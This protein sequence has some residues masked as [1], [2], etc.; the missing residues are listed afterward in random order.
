MGKILISPLPIIGHIIPAM[1]VARRLAAAGHNIKFALP[2]QIASQVSQDF[3]CV[4]TTD[5]VFSHEPVTLRLS[6]T[7]A[8]RDIA[9]LKINIRFLFELWTESQLE[10]LRKIITKELPDLIISDTHHLAPIVVALE[11]QL[12]SAVLGVT[13]YRKIFKGSAPIGSGLAPSYKMPYAYIYDS[14]N[15]IIEWRS[16]NI[17]HTVTRRLT[18]LSPGLKSILQDA[19][20]SIFGI[21]QDLGT[22][23]FQCSTPYL[24]D[25]PEVLTKHGV[26][27]IGPMN[28][29]ILSPENH[30]RF[31]GKTLSAETKKIVITWGT[32]QP[33]IPIEFVEVIKALKDFS[34]LNIVIA[35]PTKQRF[36]AK[37]LCHT[38][39]GRVRVTNTF[40]DFLYELKSADVFVSN[41]GFG[42]VKAALTLGIPVI[43]SGDQ[44]DKPDVCGRVQRTGAG[45]GLL[46][47]GIG[48]IER[49]FEKAIRLVL[50]N[51]SYKER[52]LEV[53]KELAA[54]E[55]SGALESAVQ[56][57]LSHN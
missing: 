2:T 4:T 6:A 49:R 44:D 36:E 24:E 18:D 52:A 7:N 12:P 51:A 25:Q 33:S 48:S 41:G 5:D 45:I 54:Y 8:L 10:S 1:A 31:K 34:E 38:I 50:S 15:R 30:T 17:R 46:W 9:K 35:P 19:P 16:R 20:L 29:E 42:A 3:S 32:M 39:S 27:F 21:C 22:A 23:F 40:E 26:E 11:N 43:C 13:P 53:G 37:M 14:I 28:E 55:V 56:R 47:W 57:L